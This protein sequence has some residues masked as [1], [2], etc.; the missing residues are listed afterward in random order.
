[1]DYI[2]FAIIQDYYVQK[3]YLKLTIKG[4]IIQDIITPIDLIIVQILSKDINTYKKPFNIKKNFRLSNFD[5]SYEGFS[6][7][8]I[9]FHKLNIID[10]KVLEIIFRKKN[11]LLFFSSTTP[12]PED[13]IGSWVCI[14]KKFL[15]TNNNLYFYH[16]KD[17]TAKNQFNEEIGK[18]KGYLETSAH[19]ILI[20]QLNQNTNQEIFVPFIDEF[21]EIV[22][23]D[24]DKKQIDFIKIK[25]WEYFLDT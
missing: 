7:E 4:N 20:I 10:I 23:T 22:Y 24:K 14:H 16:I 18:I 13:I 9:D 1:M 3:N 25:N 6:K 5:L 2:P 21:C 8:F 12:I 19:G 15:E 17:K 11:I